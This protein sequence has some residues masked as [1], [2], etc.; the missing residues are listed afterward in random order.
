L[1]ALGARLRANVS[2]HVTL[3]GALFNGDAAGPGPEDPQLRDNRGLNF[4]INDPP[5]VLGEVQF[6]WNGQKGDPGLDGKF[7]VGGWRHFWYFYR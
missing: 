2:D 1:A 4:R 6:I 5:L 3:V 7:K